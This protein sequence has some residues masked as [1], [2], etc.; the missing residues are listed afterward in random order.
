MP[1]GHWG[2]LLR[3]MEWLANDMAQVRCMVCVCRA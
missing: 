1:T 3:E 2:F